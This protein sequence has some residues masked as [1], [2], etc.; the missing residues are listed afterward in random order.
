[1]KRYSRRQFITGGAL[2]ALGGTL[3]LTG[4]APM[5]PEEAAEK[6]R[7]EAAKRDANSQGEVTA[8]GEGMGKHGKF[9]VEV[10]MKDGAID[11]ITVLD[12]RETPGMGDV[13]MDKMTKTIIDNQT[14]DVD[15]ISGATLS[16]MAFLT[17]VGSALDTLGED[18]N[19][20]KHREPAAWVS[21]VK[22]PDECDV[23]VIGAG[24]AGFAA[25]ITA[26]NE[27]K[28][29]VLMDKMGVLGGDTCLSG[30]EMAV[31]GN[32]IQV[33][34]GVEDSPENLISDMLVG[35]DNKG[36][37]ELVAIIANGALDSANWLTYEGGISW[38]HDLMQFGGHNIKRSIIPITH[39]GS[40]MTT[41]LTNRVNEIDNIVL[42]DNTK[43]VELIQGAD[44]A[45]TG[46]KAQNAVT[47]E[48]ATV[49]CK[50]VVLATGGFGSNID[51]R[52]KYNP[53]MDDK[54][55]S[56]DSVAA[57]GDGIVMAEA[58]G[59]DT[60]D[61]EYIQ[62]YPVCD[63]ETGALLYVGDVRLENYGIL[64]NKEGDRFVQELD[65]RDVI[66]NGIK[67][68]TDGVGFLLFNQKAADATGLVKQHAD[69]YENS[70]SRGVIVKAD[71]LE[72]VAKAQGVDPTEL[73]ATVDKWN[74][75]CAEGKDPDFG[76]SAEMNTIE[77]GP[78][79]LMAC[80]PAVHYTMGGLHITP[81][82]EV[83]TVDETVIPGLYA[84][85][86]VAGHKM[87]TNRLGSCS[88]TDIYTFGRIA[89]K[90]AADYA[91]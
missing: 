12:S 6:E 68:Q 43:A 86:E 69:E 30:G 42:V 89:G 27:G 72:E 36:D 16:S 21:D 35:G 9:N 13:A 44:G 91:A 62:T 57:T 87:G 53:D 23:V 17:A 41:K 81:E 88:M 83:L 77:D 38:K 19:E 65:R 60:I 31:P 66:S 45:I 8:I 73:Q 20:W 90:N 74:Q 84:A 4:C 33:T 22:L 28:S 5:T 50:A 59:A 2:A 3:A 55:L 64:V 10:S 52:V 82:A 67:A 15:T 37:P 47:G 54:I 14:L 61:M 58:I 56:T 1:M 63:P 51:M 25:A 29:V 26:A 32:W 75:Y 78:Y 71:T 34:Q 7:A 39:S 49:N 80:K 76:Y 18:S 85:G 24:G 40:E 46:V 70:E 79:Y 11:R 48:E